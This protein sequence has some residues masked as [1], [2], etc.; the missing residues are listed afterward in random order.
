GF[1]VAQRL[2]ASGATVAVWDRDE[3]ALASAPAAMH[4]YAVDVADADAV[5]RAAKATV[6]D[7]AR[8]DVL[9]CS[10]GIAGPNLPMWE[11]AVDRW[12][13]VID[14]NLNG[15]FYCNRAVV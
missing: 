7:L 12:R 2:A 14:V 9:V 10:A 13:Q 15:L 5:A 1:A 4:R 11:Y 3:A 8:I 6:R